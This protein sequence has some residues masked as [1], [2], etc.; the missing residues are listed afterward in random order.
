M[1]G[2]GPVSNQTKPNQCTHSFY[3]LIYSCRKY[4]TGG[5]GECLNAAAWVRTTRFLRDTYKYPGCVRR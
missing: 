1:A 5:G 3:Y 2:T 4:C